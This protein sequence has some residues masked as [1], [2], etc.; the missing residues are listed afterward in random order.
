MKCCS[1]CRLNILTEI[2]YLNYVFGVKI[3]FKSPMILIVRK[4]EGMNI[5]LGI[6]VWIIIGIVNRV[7]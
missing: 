4:Y 1:Q 7:N 6:L 2:L 5:K 3:Y